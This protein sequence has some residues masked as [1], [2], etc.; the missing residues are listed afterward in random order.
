MT[1]M[2]SFGARHVAVIAAVSAAVYVVMRA[3]EARMKGCGC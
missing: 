2:Q 3:L 1:P